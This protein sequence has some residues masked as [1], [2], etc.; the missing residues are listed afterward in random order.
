MLQIL[1]KTIKH[2]VLSVISLITDYRLLLTALAPALTSC[3]GI[4]EGGFECPPGIGVKC[5]SISEVNTMVNKRELPL[6]GARNQE[7]GGREETESSCS[8]QVMDKQI[9]KNLETPQIWW[10]PSSN[11]VS[12]FSDQTLHG[13]KPR[14]K[15]GKRRADALDDK[16]SI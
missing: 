3:M 1:R 10:A 11:Q 9:I 8:C 13:G 4:Y 15:R 12:V 6:S 5:K 7:A 2:P 14:N 16:D